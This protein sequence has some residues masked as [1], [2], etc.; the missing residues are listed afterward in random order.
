MR[1]LLPPIQN[2]REVK[3]FDEHLEFSFWPPHYTAVSSELPTMFWSTP[4]IRSGQFLK[5]SGFKNSG[6]FAEPNLD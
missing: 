6:S 2:H 3:H 1:E 5:L 4:E